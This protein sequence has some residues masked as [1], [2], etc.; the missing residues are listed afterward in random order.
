MWVEA[1]TENEKSH[2]FSQQEDHM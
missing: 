2:V 1:R